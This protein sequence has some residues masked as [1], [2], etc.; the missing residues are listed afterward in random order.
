MHNSK[1]KHSI[2][3]RLLKVQ[4]THRSNQAS[5]FSSGYQNHFWL[6]PYETRLEDLQ[7]DRSWVENGLRMK[8]LCFDRS[9]AKICIGVRTPGLAFERWRSNSNSGVRTPSQNLA[10]N[11]T[12]HSNAS[13]G[14]SNAKANSKTTALAIRTPA[15]GVRTPAPRALTVRTPVGPFERS[16]CAGRESAKN[17][18]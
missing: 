7:F 6:I 15:L 17:K 14:R 1:Y 9:V 8:K 3:V 10:N 18:A 4:P 13:L 11:A 12:G 16:A 2:W 5:P